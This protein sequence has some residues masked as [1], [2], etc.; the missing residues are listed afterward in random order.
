M[1]RALWLYASEIEALSDPEQRLKISAW[2]QRTEIR[3]NGRS[4]L[5]RE[6]TLSKS[7]QKMPHYFEARFVSASDGAMKDRHKRAVQARVW[8]GTTSDRLTED[9]PYEEAWDRSTSGRDMLSVRIYLGSSI[10]DGELLRV[11]VDWPGCSRDL[12]KREAAEEFDVRF[13]KFPVPYEHIIVL[14]DCAQA[15]KVRAIDATNFTSVPE[16]SDW[17]VSYSGTDVSIGDVRGVVLDLRR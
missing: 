10:Q 13:L 3:T 12:R 4:T 16:G 14:K 11:Q 5:T 9:V 8:R 6:L 15:P 17:H 1:A 7:S 2:Q